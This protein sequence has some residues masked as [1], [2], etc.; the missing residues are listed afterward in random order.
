MEGRGL[1]SSE[2]EYGQEAGCSEHGSE[3]SAKKVRNFLI[4]L[5]NIS[6]LKRAVHHVTVIHSS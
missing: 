6:F 3:K 2:S 5:G 1:I 4:S